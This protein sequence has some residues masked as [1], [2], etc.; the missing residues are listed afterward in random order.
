MEEMAVSGQSPKPGPVPGPGA[1][2]PVPGPGSSGP[3]PGP[4]PNDAA[5]ALAG[6]AVDPDR[7]RRQVR[8]ALDA[9]APTPADRAAYL[10]RAHALLQ[11]ALGGEGASRG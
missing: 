4:T 8:E 5:A 1:T 2:G 6:G 11:E 9:P 3:R 7:L 10:E